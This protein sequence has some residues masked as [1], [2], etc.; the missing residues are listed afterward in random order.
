MTRG[1]VLLIITQFSV[2]HCMKIITEGGNYEY[3]KALNVWRKNSKASVN[4]NYDAENIAIYRRVDISISKTIYRYIESSLVRTTS[5]YFRDGSMLEFHF[6]YDIDRT[7]TKYRD[8][9][10]LFAYFDLC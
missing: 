3:G 2:I 4:A 9:E 8:I 5:S 7:L 1:A 6:R 10:T